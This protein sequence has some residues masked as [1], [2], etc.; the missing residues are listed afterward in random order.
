MEFIERI[1]KTRLG[2]HG[3]QIVVY[4]D[5]LSS[6]TI[7]AGSIDFESVGKRCLEA[8]DGKFIKEKYNLAEGLD[9]GNKLHQERIEWM[10]SLIE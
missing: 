3:L 2:L 4:S 9:F 5:K 6:R 1:S 8:V 10:K 7:D